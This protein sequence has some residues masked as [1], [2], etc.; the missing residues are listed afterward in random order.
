MSYSNISLRKALKSGELAPDTVNAIES[1][2]QKMS[3]KLN[4]EVTNSEAFERL[5][6]EVF[7]EIVVVNKNI[8]MA[9]KAETLPEMFFEQDAGLVLTDYMAQL[10]KRVAF[11]ETAGKDG[12]KVY[13]KIKTL[14]DMGGR[15]EAEL[16]YKAI[17]SF[18]GTIELDKK[19]NWSPKTKGILND[20]V[21]FQVATKIGLG[22]ATIPNLTQPFISS[23]L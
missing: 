6:N 20:L 19:Y 7:S 9:R 21:N 15:N 3:K 18:T 14:R 5:R 10:A 13:D 23:V 12:S 11:V 8:E 2:R 16:L 17:N 22:F 1:I 4:R